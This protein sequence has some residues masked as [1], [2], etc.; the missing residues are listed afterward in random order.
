MPRQADFRREQHRWSKCSCLRHNIALVEQRPT[1]FDVSIME[2]IRYGRME[3]TDDEVAAAREAAAHDFT[4]HFLEDTELLS[5]IGRS[6]LGGQV[7]R[8]AIARALL[9]DPTVII[10]DEATSGLD[11][12]SAWEALKALLRLTLT[13][14]RGGHPAHCTSAVHSQE[15]GGCRCNEGWNDCPAGSYEDLMKD[16]DGHL[17]SWIRTCEKWFKVFN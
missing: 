14:G 9:R 1:L 5:G 2:N 10:L 16:A 4:L 8:I 15:G 6:A 7:Q 17:F 11:L 13:A 3:A 12:D